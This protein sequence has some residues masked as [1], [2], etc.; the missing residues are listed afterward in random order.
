MRRQLNDAVDA[1]GNV[2]CTQTRLY[3][4]QER[5]NLRFG[6]ILPPWLG[7]EVDLAA[8]EAVI[9]EAYLEMVIFLEIRGDPLGDCRQ[10]P[11]LLRRC[12][13]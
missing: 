6:R 3:S 12:S 2:C 8:I 5:G 13:V 4:L 1:T 11:V 10:G 9:D 7:N